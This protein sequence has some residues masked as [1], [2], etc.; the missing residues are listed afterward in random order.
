MRDYTSA[1]YGDVFA[2]LYDE[3]HPDDA[4]VSVAVER[5]NKEAGK[6]PALEL[7]IGTGRLALPLAATGRP[8]HGIESSPAMIKRLEAKVAEAAGTAGRGRLPVSASLGDMADVDAPGPFG[9]AY[10]TFNTFWMLLEQEQQVRCCQNV[11]RSLAPDG[12][13]VVEGSVPDVATLAKRRSAE[14]ARITADSV[15]VDLTVRDPVA[16]RIDRQQLVADGSGFRLLPLSFRYVWPS[17]LDLMARI[18][19]LRL[20][21][22][23]SDWEA[24]P[25]TGASRAHVSVYELA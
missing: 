1:T 10:V 21:A 25:F 12:A 24:T 14:P 7:G 3:W 15:A 16:Q 9:L 19:G 4:A 17:E 2:D 18:A 8:V 22:R 6:G 23:Y 13:F 5:L 11:A 20:R